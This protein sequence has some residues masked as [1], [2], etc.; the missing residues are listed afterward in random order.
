MVNG[1]GYDYNLITWLGAN[2]L[3]TLTPAQVCANI[4]NTCLHDGPI[5]LHDTNFN[6]NNVQINNTLI[7]ETIQAKI[8]KIGF[9]QIR[10][11]IFQQLC[12]GYSN[13]P[14]AAIEHIR[15][16]SNCPDGQLVTATTIEYYQRM[17]NAVRPFATQHTYAI[18]ICDKF[19]QG[20][21]QRIL[22]PFHCFYP[23][24]SAVHDLTGTNQCSQ[25]PIILAAAQA[26]EDKVK[27]M[28]DIAHGMLGQSFYSNIIG[29][30]E[31]P[32]FPSQAKKTLTH[33][34]GR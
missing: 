27:Q 20:L 3:S 7:V 33:Y 26:V 1:H 25:L 21:D 14:H 6:L 5:T 10:A 24:H 31:V 32:A 22:G 13:Q 4:L 29:G 9:K 16:S 28:Q 34:Q 8:L 19:I 23:N 2:D 12:P 15:Q 11:S 30:G 17:L 18:S